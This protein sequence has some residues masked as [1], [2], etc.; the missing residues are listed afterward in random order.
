[1]DPADL[2]LLRELEKGLPLV[3]HPYAEI[4]AYLGISEDEAIRRIR[5]LKDAGII[6]RMRVR[7]NQRSI[8]IVANALVAWRIPEEESDAA[9][10]RLAAVQGVTHCYRRMQVAGR[11]E[12]TVYT[13]HHGWTEEQ[14]VQEI[15]GIAEM[16]GYSEYVVL[17]STEEYKRTPHIR[18]DDLEAGR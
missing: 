18:A 17:F 4:G 8:G 9:G 16:T 10:F 7:I 3:P 6:R 13:V 2:H 14:V 12:Y 11:W 1:M 15:A 5:S